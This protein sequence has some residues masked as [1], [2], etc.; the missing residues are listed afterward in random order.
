MFGTTGLKWVKFFVWGVIQIILSPCEAF[1]SSQSTP[2][3]LNL[4][5]TYSLTLKMPYL[6]NRWSE[7]AE[8]LCVGSYSDCITTL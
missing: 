4:E 3:T 6:W 1:L 2:S 8:I 7:L 5:S